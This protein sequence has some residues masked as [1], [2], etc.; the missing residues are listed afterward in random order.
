MFLNHILFIDRRNFFYL[1]QYYNFLFSQL[2][3][4]IACNFF[5]HH[6]LQMIKQKVYLLLESL[7]QLKHLNIC[8]ELKL[9][10]RMTF[11]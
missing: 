1:S 5:D 2:E 4:N 6:H 10:F 9:I 3:D 11:K 8:F 7:D